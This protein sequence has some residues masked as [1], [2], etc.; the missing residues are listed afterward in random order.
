MKYYPWNPGDYG[1]RT[2]HLTDA[3][4]I[5]YRR[6]LDWQ[7]MAEAPLPLSEARVVYRIAGADHWRKQAGV[8]RVVAEFFDADGWNPRA[9]EVI[10][11]FHSREAKRQAKRRP[12]E[13]KHERSDN[14]RPQWKRDDPLERSRA[15]FDR[16]IHELGG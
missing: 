14:N 6:L 8:D 7:Y 11:D 9:R 1:G 13:N 5:A 12:K 4:D 10:R 16:A 2:G 3:Q 15:A